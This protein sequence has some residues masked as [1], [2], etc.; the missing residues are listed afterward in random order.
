MTTK[1]EAEKDDRDPMD[2]AI[3][4]VRRS[5]KKAEQHNDQHLA[6]LLKRHEAALLLLSAE[7]DANVSL[8]AG[9]E[10]TTL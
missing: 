3:D 5:R 4:S 6:A 9:N 7:R 10:G 1:K 2:T 8:F